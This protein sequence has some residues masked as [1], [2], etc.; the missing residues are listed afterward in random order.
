MDL[1]PRD[2]APARTHAQS[3]A[4][5]SDA[6]PWVDG[7][8]CQPSPREGGPDPGPQWGW[9]SGGNNG[10]PILSDSTTD[11]DTGA[12]DCER[13]CSR[14]AQPL[15]RRPGDA[16]R[17]PGATGPVD[18]AGAFADDPRASASGR[19]TPLRAAGR[20]LWRCELPDGSPAADSGGPGGPWFAYNF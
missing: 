11:S 8:D 9:D 14:P 12:S 3:H 6:Q 15:R 4:A 19:E 1:A 16:A 18:G 5:A 20:A 17:P 2:A 10:E 7:W 13:T